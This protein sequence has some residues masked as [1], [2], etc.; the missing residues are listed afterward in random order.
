MAV[1]NVPADFAPLVRPPADD[2]RRWLQWKGDNID[3][4]K[5]VFPDLLWVVHDY[6]HPTLILHPN[7]R[8]ENGDL[9]YYR[10]GEH[11][12]H[13][14]DWFVSDDITGAHVG[15]Y[16]GFSFIKGVGLRRL[17]HWIGDFGR[18]PYIRALFPSIN[19]ECGMYTTPDG[20]A[21]PVLY[22]M[23][24]DYQ[25]ASDAPIMPMDMD[26]VIHIIYPDDWIMTDHNDPNGIIV[27]KTLAI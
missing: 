4:F 8:D 9:V 12:A 16:S 7:T 25:Q 15:L 26:D 6:H 11:S 5:E 17:V 23:R 3:E 22:Q 27:S 20:W 21:I 14:G 13:V 19:F 2:T 18:V 24:P 1:N 10:D